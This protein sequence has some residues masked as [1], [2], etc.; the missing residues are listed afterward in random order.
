MWLIVVNCCSEGMI[1]FVMLI[2]DL[3]LLYFL[4]SCTRVMLLLICSWVKLVVLDDSSLSLCVYSRGVG[5]VNVWFMM[6]VVGVYGCMG[7]SIGVKNGL[8]LVR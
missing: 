4:V 7:C 6:L 1:L 5:L 8:V 2:V 3:L